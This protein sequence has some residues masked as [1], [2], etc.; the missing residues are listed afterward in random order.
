LYSFTPYFLQSAKKAQTQ[1]VSTAYDPITSS[2]VT[3]T[4]T[5]YLRQ[6]LSP[7]SHPK[8][9]TTST[10]DS[11][12]STI[13]YAF[14]FRIPTCDGIP[15]SL[16]YYN[17]VIHDDSVQLFA[18]IGT[19]PSAAGGH[20]PCRYDTFQDFRRNV[21]L[22]RIQY[23]NYRR[24]SYSDSNNLLSACYLNSINTADPLLKTRFAATK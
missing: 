12:V 20:W 4:N 17:T 11:L 22:A 6:S 23:I 18:N 10:G 2:A 1:V 21:N 24:R 14:D 19:C 7:R 3:S 5:V 13:K 9:S 8:V 15:D 16:P